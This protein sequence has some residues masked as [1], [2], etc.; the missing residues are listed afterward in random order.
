M[1][2]VFWHKLNHSEYVL[3]FFSIESNGSLKFLKSRRELRKFLKKI[4]MN[5]AVYIKFR[6]IIIFDIDIIFKRIENG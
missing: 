3:K 1:I 4:E 5:L 6:I 2:T